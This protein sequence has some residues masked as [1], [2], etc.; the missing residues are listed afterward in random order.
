MPNEE[1]L[2]GKKWS[3]YKLFRVQ[4]H[5]SAVGPECVSSEERNVIGQIRRRHRYEKVDARR[6]WGRPSLWWSHL[7]FG[8]LVSRALWMWCG[9]GVL[10]LDLEQ[11]W[12]AVWGLITQPEEF[13]HAER[14]SS[15]D[16]PFSH[17]ARR[18]VCLRSATRFVSWHQ[19]AEARLNVY[20][21]VWNLNVLVSNSLLTRTL[22]EIRYFSPV[23]VSSKLQKNVQPLMWH[24]KSC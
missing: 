24:Y 3:P 7:L 1:D 8:R 20:L 13:V 17:A 11:L 2:T 9:E 22:Q 18:P 6:G 10:L 23:L 21:G 5:V 15:P 14:A 12:N 19:S 16:S 4:C